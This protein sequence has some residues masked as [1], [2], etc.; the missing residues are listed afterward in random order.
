MYGIYLQEKSPPGA[1]IAENFLVWH[2][3][4]ECDRENGGY[5]YR[6]KTQHM[7][8]ATLV[9]AWRYWYELTDGFWGQFS[10]TQNPH[11]YPKHLL[12]LRFKHL[13]SMQSF[14][15]TVEYVCNWFWADPSTVIAAGGKAF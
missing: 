3:A 2:R 1:T 8:T 13:T 6:G 11:K 4:R 12:P 10:A 14:V 7:Y 9:I 5:T 15:G